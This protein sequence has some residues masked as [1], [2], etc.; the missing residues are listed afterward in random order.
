MRELLLVTGAF[1]RL[2]TWCCPKLFKLL[3]KSWRNCFISLTLRYCKSDSSSFLWNKTSDSTMIVRTAQRKV[4]R[5]I[6]LGGGGRECVWERGGEETHL[7]PSSFLP[8]SFPLCSSIRRHP[9]LS[10]QVEQASARIQNINRRAQSTS[11]GYKSFFIVFSLWKKRD[12]GKAHFLA[13]KGAYSVSRKKG[14]WEKKM[15]YSLADPP[16]HY[17]VTGKKG[18]WKKKMR[19]ILADPPFQ[20]SVSGKKGSWKKKMKYFLSDPPFQY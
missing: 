6:Q 19:Y 11:C 9:A 17:S 2:L 13:E 10:E 7:S 18:S 20:Y 3:S 4:R 1:K 12:S 14:I 5:K 15:K 16:F 8:L